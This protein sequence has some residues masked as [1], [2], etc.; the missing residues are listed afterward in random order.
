MCA[1]LANLLCMSVDTNMS[2]I[3]NFDILSDIFY[4]QKLHTIVI[5][6]FKKAEKKQ[7]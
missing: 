1:L 4:L 6:L 3:G 5:S 2:K 7:Q